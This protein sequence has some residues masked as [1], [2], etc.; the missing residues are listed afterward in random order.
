[1][2]IKI[3]YL[4][5][6][7]LISLYTG[8]GDKGVIS[9]DT[10]VKPAKQIQ[11]KFNLITTNNETIQVQAIDQGL[12]FKGYEGKVILLNLFGTWCPPCKAEIP[13][14]N[15]IKNALT[16][17][18]EVIGIDVGLRSGGLT[19]MD[20][21]KSFITQFNIQYP[22]TS[23]GDNMKLQNYLRSLN[24]SGSIPFMILFDQKGNYIT[25]YIGM[26][27]EEMMRSDIDQL[28]KK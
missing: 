18:F 11:P 19:P 2:K 1:M 8:C 20:T 14:L 22:I 4:L 21:I 6:F 17:E 5:T 25:H 3:A 24:A 7:L 27:P 9:K 28:L 13:H 15:N 16:D 23:R 26:V 12:V 10:I